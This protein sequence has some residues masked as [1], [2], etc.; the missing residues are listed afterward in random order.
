MV[1]LSLGTSGVVFATTDG[2]LIDPEGRL[3]SFCH[4]VP[5]A[6]A[7]DGR[8]AVGG[9]QPPVVPRRARSRRGVRRRSSTRPR[10]A[11]GERRPAVPA[12]PVGRADPVPGPARARGVRRARG[13]PR[14]PAHDPLGP[15]GRGLRAAR[16]ARADAGGRAWAG[17]T[18]SGRRAAGARAALWRQILADVL[19]MPVVT[20]TTSEGAAQG[21][22]MLAAVGRGLVRRRARR[23][24]GALVTLGER[25]E[26]SDR[27]RLP[28][29]HTAQYR[30]LYP[31]LAP[32]F[33]SIG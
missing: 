21:A 25:V 1:S 6:M 11:A 28:R 7:R 22:A 19:E 2:P 26:P 24:A 33:H 17:S 4:A 18:R 16:L 30:A 8:D 12:L 20:T 23:P 15:G 31:A 29:A 14:P 27:R 5:D 9:R 3:H 32:T 13:A 10:R